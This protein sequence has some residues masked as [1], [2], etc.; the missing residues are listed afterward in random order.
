M[1]RYCK[2]VHTSNEVI[3]KKFIH[4]AQP[5]F[6][7]EEKKEIISALDSGWVTLGPR[8]RQ[9]EEEFAKYVGSKF[10][11]AVSSC[12]AGIHISLIVAGIQ[13]G[14]EVITTPMSFV[15]TVNPVVHLGAKPV[16]V[17]IDPLTFNIDVSKIEKKITKKTKAIIPVHYGGQ[18]AN[19]DKI[20]SLAKKY[21]LKVI[22]DAAHGTGGSFNGRKI[23]T[24]GDFVNFSF[25]PIKNMS[26]GDG[27]MITTNNEEAASKLMMLRLH[28]MSRDAW[29]RH[30]ANGSWRYDIE[31]PGYKYN[32]TD[33]SAALGIRQLEKVDSFIK[34]RKDYAKIYDSLLADVPEITT[35]YVGK[36]EDHIYSLYSVLLDTSNLKISRD[37]VIEELKKANIGSSVY[38][39]PIHL[40]TYYKKTY[41][42]KLGDFPISEEVFEKIISLPLYPRMK[43]TDIHYVVKTLKKIISS[44]RK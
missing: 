21:K 18:A 28:G 29:K 8:T 35:P 40:F 10:A 31:Y 39:I 24:H 33:L 1:E 34:T 4:F 41:K 27:G 26:T 20:M 5:L 19:M 16:F 23:G 2:K 12:T 9:F 7:H 13:P 3:M 14:D 11:I 36:D 6:G 30:A 15:A 37:Q 43:K 38:F 17:D 25:H 42:Y 32:M 44:N 22:E